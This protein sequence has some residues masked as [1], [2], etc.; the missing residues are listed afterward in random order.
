M[1]YNN[2]K[3]L[4]QILGVNK[5]ASQE[6]IIKI[7]Q[8][9]IPKNSSGPVQI[10]QEIGEAMME[11]AFRSSIFE[12]IISKI[13]INTKLCYHIDGHRVYVEYVDGGSC[14]KC[15]KTAKL[16]RKEYEYQTPEY[17][18]RDFEYN[19]SSPNN[20]DFEFK[21]VGC[22][23]KGQDFHQMKDGSYFCK[24]CFEE[25]LWRKEN[26]SDNDK[27]DKYSAPN[28]YGNQNHKSPE[29]P[30][31][32][33]I[34]R[35]A[36][37]IE[38]YKRKKLAV[39]EQEK[40][41]VQAEIDRLE[42]ELK[43]EK[44]KK[45]FV[46]K[47]GKTHSVEVNRLTGKT[48]TGITNISLNSQGNLVV[49]YGNLKQTVDNNNLTPEQ[50]EIKDVLD[51]RVSI[52]IINDKIKLLGGAKKDVIDVIAYQKYFDFLEKLGLREEFSII[53]A[54]DSLVLY[55]TIIRPLII[56]ANNN[57]LVIFCHGLTNNRWSLFYAMHLALQRGY[58]VVSYDARN[59]GLS[60]KS[61]TSLGQIEACDLQDVIDYVRKKYQ[62]TKIG[63]YG[64]SMGAATLT[65]WLGYFA[66]VGNSEVAFA[67]C[68]APFDSF[69]TQQKR[70]LGKK[71]NPY[72]VLPQD[73]PIKLLLFHGLEDAVID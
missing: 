64:F 62:P 31:S 54:H 32:D 15:G 67:I 20:Q 18:A 55:G 22:H 16:R 25:E 48:T 24:L 69:L 52:G 42:K 58:Q 4:Y 27:K 53:T 8:D 40:S 13:H 71:L 65:F 61:A 21:C 9:L 51:I 19:P 41:G 44:L 23:K 33:P 39:S 6:Q 43:N 12:A 47:G 3:D 35:L 59:H 34:K 63:L 14:A 70:A 50:A 10:S 30:D 7:S 49:E 11:F 56:N 1:N 72:L 26:P 37:A 38:H 60:G 5:N 57:K 2:N 66:G 45:F 46:E 68:E 17:K 29:Q 36:K 28:S 73:L